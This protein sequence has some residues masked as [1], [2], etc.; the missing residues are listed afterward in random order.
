L[1]TRF[2]GPTETNIN[3]PVEFNKSINIGES[4]GQD[5]TNYHKY[6]NTKT[7]DDIYSRI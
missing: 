7:I 2:S 6:S 4:S 5:F 3:K 1:Q